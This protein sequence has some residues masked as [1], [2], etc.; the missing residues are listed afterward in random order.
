VQSFKQSFF[1][2]SAAEKADI[3]RSFRELDLET[4]ADRSWGAPVASEAPKSKG[5]W[6]WRNRDPLLV[7]A[8]V[9]FA[10]LFVG[11]IL[12]SQANNLTSSISDLSSRVDGLSS[13]MDNQITRLDNRIGDLDKRMESRLGAVEANI[14]NQFN[15]VNARFGK[16]DDDIRSMSEIIS[17]MRVDIGRLLYATHLAPS[18]DAAREQPQP[19]DVFADSRPPGQSAPPTAGPPEPVIQ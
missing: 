11:Y 18:A 10:A 14:G 9:G 19:P 5:N 12:T 13:R 6:F 2:F 15:T 4:S 17:N 7:A 1:S 8:L 3:V 16:I